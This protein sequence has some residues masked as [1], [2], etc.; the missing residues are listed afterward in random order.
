MSDET[1]RRAEYPENS[2]PYEPAMVA[3]ARSREAAELL[4]LG[5]CRSIRAGHRRQPAFID[6]GS[7]GDRDDPDPVGR[8]AGRGCPLPGPVGACMGE[9]NQEIT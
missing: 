4:W 9:L 3:V 5:V 1:I 6:M 8:R 7:R 2:V